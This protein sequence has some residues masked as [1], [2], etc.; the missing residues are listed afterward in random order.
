MVY[1]LPNGETWIG[2]SGGGPGLKAI[3]AY[4]PARHAFVSVS[5]SGSK[6]AEA[7]ALLLLGQLGSP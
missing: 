1:Q 7:T 5:L 4:A 6:G 2:H 3:V